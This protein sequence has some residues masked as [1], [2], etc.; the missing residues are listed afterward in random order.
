MIET[1]KLI[2]GDNV[3]VLKDFP[4]ECIN[5]TVTSPPYDL[6]RN[7]K[8]KVMDTKHNGYSFP[9]EPLAR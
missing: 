7:Y 2:C 3:E 8:G 9:F 1:N 4:D 6:I 5:L